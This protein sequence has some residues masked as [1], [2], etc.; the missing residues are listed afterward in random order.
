MDASV[1]VAA[2]DLVGRPNLEVREAIGDNFR[3]RAARPRAVH[4]KESGCC[5]TRTYLKIDTSID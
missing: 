2:H 4:L 1:I 3:S 5:A